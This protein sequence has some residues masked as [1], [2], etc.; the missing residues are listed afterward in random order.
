MKRE[1]MCEMVQPLCFNPNIN[2]EIQLYKCTYNIIYIQN[3]NAAF[4]SFGDKVKTGSIALRNI[5][6]D[7]QQRWNS[8]FVIVFN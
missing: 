2:K 5:K 8:L 7:N 4:F 3:I 6:F 1:K